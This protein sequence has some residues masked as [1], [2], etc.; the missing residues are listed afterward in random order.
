M[1]TRGRQR[2]GKSER[3]DLGDE[4]RRVVVAA[5]GVLLK[6]AGAVEQR[7]N[8]AD[9]IR[10][11]QRDLERADGIPGEVEPE[12]EVDDALVVP[13]GIQAFD[14]VEDVEA[15]HSQRELEYSSYDAAA[16]LDSSSGPSDRSFLGE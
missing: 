4:D 14:F 7:G 8:R 5:L 9:A 11:L 12:G 3:R 6:L 2:P 16:G 1:G 15:A 13:F 10:A